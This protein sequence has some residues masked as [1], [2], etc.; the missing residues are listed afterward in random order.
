MHGQAEPISNIARPSRATPDSQL[1]SLQAYESAHSFWNNRLFAACR[2]GALTKADFQFVFSQYYL[3]SKNFT[4]FLSGLL[5]NL[6]D[7][8]LR[9]R[10][11]ENLW[12]EG[13]GAAPEQRHAQ[14][15][16]NFLTAGLGI[17]VAAIQFESCARL[18]VDQFLANCLHASALH[19]SAFLSL[20]TEGIVS[21]SYTIFVEGLRKAG[22]EEQQL[23]F[24]H[25]HIACDDAHAATM[26]DILCSFR[27]QTD[28]EPQ[29]R[30]SLGLSLDLR[31]D[32]FDALMNEVQRRRVDGHLQRINQKQSLLGA[33]IRDEQLRFLPAEKQGA[34]LY[35]NKVDAMNIEFTADRAPF[36][37]EVIDTRVVRIPPHKNNERHKHA[38]ETVFYFVSGTGRVM[39]DDRW[40]AVKPGDS[41][42]VPRWAVHQSQNLGATEMVIL[43]ITDF[44][45][46]GKAFV[47]DYEST[48]RMR[49]AAH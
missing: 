36:P 4:R 20:G 34:T 23:E 13:G 32:F 14:I 41:V 48:A 35:A 24:F 27:E 33:D 43:A 39:V 16:R 6:D 45:L 37:A 25:L 46:T 31:R 3:Y 38:H 42:F 49:G 15:F 9:S 10:L 26:H 22:I 44:F 5:A 11:T 18:F 7:D 40:I 12:E 47:G 17:D 29:C 30:S 2:A 8:L 1:A 21:R 28:W 19:A